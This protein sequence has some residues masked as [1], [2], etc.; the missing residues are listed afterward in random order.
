MPGKLM[1]RNSQNQWQFA[2]MLAK[3]AGRN[4]VITNVNRGGGYVIP[5]E[6][7]L[8]ASLRLNNNQKQSIIH[9]LI[10]LSHR[11][12][13]RFNSYKYSSQIGIDFGLDQHHK[14]WIIEVNFDYPSHELFNN[15]KDKTMYR[16]IKSLKNSYLKSL[17]AGMIRRK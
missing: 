5:I 10:R 11:I 17:R 12:C 14:I 15:L 16:K 7:A 8:G 2:G 1:M 9:E 3:V 4:S 13:N 6:K